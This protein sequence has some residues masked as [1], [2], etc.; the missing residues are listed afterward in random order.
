MNEIWK[1]VVGYEG[2]YMVS[3]L[4]QVKSLFRYKKVLK[5]NITRNGYATVELFKNKKGKR[6]LIHRLVAAAFISNPENKPQVNHRDENKLNNTVDNLVWNT[7]KENMNHGTRTKRQIKSTDYGT[8]ERKLIAR[9][10]GKMACK[11][12]LQLDLAG[13]VINRFNSGRQASAATG[14]RTTK[15]SDTLRGRHK[16]AGGYVWKYERRSDLLASQF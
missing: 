2:L 15:I 8:E 7:R 1:D 16:T 6:L 3:S 4:G 11:S 14:I 10:N 9:E 5:P 12:I 13:N